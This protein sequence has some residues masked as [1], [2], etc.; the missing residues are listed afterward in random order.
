MSTNTPI[1]TIKF[2]E[3]FSIGAGNTQISTGLE[4]INDSLYLLLTSSKGELFGDPYYGTNL[5][6]ETFEYN[7]AIHNEIIK[8]DI[9]TAIAKYEKRIS[10]SEDDI[11]I[12]NYDNFVYI[13]IHFKV[14]TT[15][16]TA[17]Y[18]ITFAKGG[19]YSGY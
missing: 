10:V 17:D 12:V 9:A 13:T 1:R 15:N 2:P 16:Q 7:S 6:K 5:M 8:N 4:S 3:I 18:G 11:N 19:D 14:I